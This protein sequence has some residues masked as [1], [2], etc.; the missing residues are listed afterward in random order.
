M[1]WPGSWQDLHLGQIS[2]LI[3]VCG[4]E[5]VLHFVQNETGSFATVAILSGYSHIAQSIIASAFLSESVISH[6]GQ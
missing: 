6:L 2:S 3:S 4:I 5:Y 1:Q